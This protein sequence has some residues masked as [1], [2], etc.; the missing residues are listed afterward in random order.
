[1]GDACT[2]KTA[3]TQVFNSGGNTYPKNYVMVWELWNYAISIIYNSN[4]I[5]HHVCIHISSCILLDNWRRIFRETDSHPWDQHG[6][7]A[8]HIRLRRAVYLQSSGD[9]FKI[10]K[11]L[12]SFFKSVCNITC[13]L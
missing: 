8:V 9:E 12:H 4:E 7:W 10:C 13:H 5:P 3:L 2:G 6:C 11:F 1:V